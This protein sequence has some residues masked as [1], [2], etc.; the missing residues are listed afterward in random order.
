MACEYKL[1][2]M[3][4]QCEVLLENQRKKF[5]PNTDDDVLSLRCSF[6]RSYF[7][8]DADLPKSV[9]HKHSRI[10]KKEQPKYNTHN[11]DKLFQSVVEYDDKKYS[12]T[13]W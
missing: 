2:G 7:P 9:L 5:K 10:H 4:V 13:C 1:Q 6:N 3:L 11:I 12:S 8:R